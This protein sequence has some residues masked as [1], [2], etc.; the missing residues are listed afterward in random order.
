MHD[1]LDSPL[2]CRFNGFALG[3]F[4]GGANFEMAAPRYGAM[5]RRMH[6]FLV[7]Q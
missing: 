2:Y 1:L 3:A 7:E 4:L 5:R 6:E